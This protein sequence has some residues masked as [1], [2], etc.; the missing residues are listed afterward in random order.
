MDFAWS[1]LALG[2][3]STSVSLCLVAPLGARLRSALLIHLVNV[4]DVSEKS[5]CECECEC[6]SGC[7]G[8]G[9][10]V[11]ECKEELKKRGNEE[12]VVVFICEPNAQ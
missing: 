5:I 11:D 10:G 2:S 1:L 6:E 8:A 3:P 9:A 7:A 4:S 12:R